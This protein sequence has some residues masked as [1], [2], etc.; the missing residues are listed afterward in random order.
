MAELFYEASEHIVY[1]LTGNF[2]RDVLM[3]KIEYH[4]A[5]R[6]SQTFSFC[7]AG[8]ALTLQ[9]GREHARRSRAT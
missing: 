1:A 5:L 9:S 7:N 2:C 8:S 3:G 6:P 4:D